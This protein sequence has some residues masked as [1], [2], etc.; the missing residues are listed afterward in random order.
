V[1]YG[2]DEAW[3]GAFPDLT[4]TELMA[5]GLGF[6]SANAVHDDIASATRALSSAMTNPASGGSG[7]SGGSSGGG[8][9][10]GGGGSW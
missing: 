10:G 1:I 4:P 5:Y 2:V 7:A 9:G 6:A 3:A 8:G